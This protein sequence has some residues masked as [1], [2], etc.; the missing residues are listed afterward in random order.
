MADLTLED[1]AVWLVGKE[2]VIK[3]DRF[4]STEI[5]IR[6]RDKNGEI[7]NVRS[8]DLEDLN[9]FQVFENKVIEKLSKLLLPGHLEIRY[10]Y[11]TL[12]EEITI[13]YWHIISGLNHEKILIERCDSNVL[14]VRF[15][16]LIGLIK[17]YKLEGEK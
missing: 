8:F 15:D 4:N 13:Q 2:D 14:E 17:L 12:I 7:Q 1:I 16:C 5:I 6:L 3:K 9:M 11:D 10:L